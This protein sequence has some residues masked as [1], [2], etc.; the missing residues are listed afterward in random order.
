MSMGLNQFERPTFV[1]HPLM[2]P[3]RP[4]TSKDV[5]VFIRDRTRICSWAVRRKDE[6]GREGWFF[7]GPEIEVP[8]TRP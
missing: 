4:K 6:A 5:T 7:V 2:V 3:H 8:S 1:N